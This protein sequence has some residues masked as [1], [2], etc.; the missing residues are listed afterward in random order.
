[1]TGGI[2]EMKEKRVQDDSQSLRCGCHSLVGER[3]TEQGED[4]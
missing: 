2:W 4:N 1:M 3:E